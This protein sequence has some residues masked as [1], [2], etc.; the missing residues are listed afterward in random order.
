V[1]QLSNLRRDLAIRH[2]VGCFHGNDAATEFVPLEPL[3]QLALCLTR[4][5]D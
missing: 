4:T 3:S 1:K 2:L 5:K